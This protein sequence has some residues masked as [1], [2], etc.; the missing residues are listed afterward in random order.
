MVHL[1]IKIT[2]QVKAIKLLIRFQS[3]MLKERCHTQDSVHWQDKHV[4]TSKSNLKAIQVDQ[5]LSGVEMGYVDWLWKPVV[6]GTGSRLACVLLMIRFIWI[7]LFLKHWNGWALLDMNYTSNKVEFK[8]FIIIIK[9]F[10]YFV[11]V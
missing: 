11:W 9:W 5:L 6:V 2:S 8:I 1:Y 10:N 4:N 3:I 7:Y